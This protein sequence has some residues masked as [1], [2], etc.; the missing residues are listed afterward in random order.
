MLR[1]RHYYIPAINFN[2]RDTLS[3]IDIRLVVFAVRLMSQ[4]IHSVVNL[5]PD[6]AKSSGLAPKRTASPPLYRRGECLTLAPR[7]CE[8]SEDLR[9]PMKLDYDRMQTTQS[10]LN[11]AFAALQ[12][13]R[14]SEAVQLFRQAQPASPQNITLY[15]GLAYAFAGLG[16]MRQAEQAI[17]Q[18]LRLDP[19]NIRSLIFKGDRRAVA[20]E[21]RKAA[22]FYDAALRSASTVPQIPQDLT[23]D[24]ARIQSLTQSIMREY[25]NEI[26]QRLKDQGFS[27][28][29]RSPRFQRSLDILVGKSNIYAQEPTA[30]YYPELPQIEFYERN[31]FDWAEAVEAH[32]EAIRGAL[33][34]ELNQSEDLFGAYVQGDDRPH[35]DPHNMVGNTDWSARFFWKDG[36]RQ[37]EALS[38]HSAVEQAL[39]H[40]PLCDIP[41]ATPSVLFSRLKP[42]AAI[43]PHNGLL[44]VRLIC[45]LPLVIP[46]NGFLRV[47][48]QKRSWTE[49]ELLVFDDSIEHEAANQSDAERV[50]LLF[51][52]WRP[53]LSKE[54][55][56]LIRALLSGFE[57]LKESR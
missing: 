48:S 11:A 33:L 1:D 26:L 52:I 5:L 24:L 13:G 22:S 18:A 49:G 46:G 25:E 16:D 6:G 40:A 3:L 17:D 20:G 54:E 4:A 35:V 31:Q 21:T 38:R 27:R 30:Y 34:D 44:N 36:H 39:S 47:G 29:E 50:I 7:Q 37:E 10:P 51:D 8:L 32:T 23:A 12:A 45:H 57:T 2:L 28:P 43:P 56:D 15:I 55:Q 9:T 41:G 14:H 19:R 42:H 53:E